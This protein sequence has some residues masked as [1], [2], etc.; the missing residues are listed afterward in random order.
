M[1]EVGER[2]GERVDWI[3]DYSY[4]LSQMNLS[5]K[6]MSCINLKEMYAHY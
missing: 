4:I 3:N 1:V 6:I 2:R 5:F